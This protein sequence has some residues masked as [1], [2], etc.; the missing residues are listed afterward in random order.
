MNTPISEGPLLKHTRKTVGGRTLHYVLEVIQQPDRARACGSGPKSSADRRPVDPPPIVKLN[1]FEGDTYEQAKDITFDYAAEFFVFVSLEN[2]RPMAHGRVQTQATS[3]PPVLTGLPVSACCYLDRPEPAGYFLFPDLSVRHEGFYKLIFRLYE[4]NKD[5]Q[6]LTLGS[7]KQEPVSEE[8]ADGFVTHMM[9]VKS[10][11]FQVYSAKKFPGL[12][13]STSLS[14]TVAEQGCRVRIRRDVRMRRRPE[15]GGD[16][17]DRRSQSPNAFRDRSGSHSS[18]DRGVFSRRTSAYE[19]PPPPPPPLAAAR[20]TQNRV[21]DFGPP[22]SSFPPPPAPTSE[23]N[24]P[25]RAYPRNGSLS[26]YPPPPPPIAATGPRAS[27][28][29]PP[30]SGPGPYSYGTDDR[31]PSLPHIINSGRPSMIGV[32]PNYALPPIQPRNSIASTD[33]NTS[34]TKTESSPVWSPNS[35]M[36]PSSGGKPLYPT[37][38]SLSTKRGLSEEEASFEGDHLLTGYSSTQLQYKRSSGDVVQKFSLGDAAEHGE[39]Q[40]HPDHELPIDPTL[41]RASVP[42]ATEEI[43]YAEIR[44]QEVY[45]RKR[46]HLGRNHSVGYG[47]VIEQRV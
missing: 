11:T 33:G 32:P 47:H 19:H 20:P 22:S 27:P 24:T 8:A 21:L 18:A 23:P 42:G 3:T 16:K 10:V 35:S 2:A 39:K 14:R 29:P 9:E 46:L 7:E 40:Y 30:P 38:S 26:S 12:G 6:D 44:D 28:Y 13:E 4:K 37:Q 17:A 15:K 31:R 5:P 45:A 1:V 25:I 43:K 41:L 34:S 36:S